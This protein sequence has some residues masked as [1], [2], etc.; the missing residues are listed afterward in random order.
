MNIHNEKI[1]K[2]KKKKNEK[3]KILIVSFN[4]NYFLPLYKS[5]NEVVRY[6]IILIVWSSEHVQA[7]IIIIVRIIICEKDKKKG[8]WGEVPIGLRYF[9][10][11]TFSASSLN[12][13]LCCLHTN[14]DLKL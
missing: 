14:Q 5:D 2:L 4:S 7:I 3:K 6:G 8:F 13:G 11:A 9:S 1:F 12:P 10:T